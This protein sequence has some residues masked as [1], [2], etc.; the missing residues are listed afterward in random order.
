ML[1][2]PHGGTLIN[3]VLKPEKAEEAAA[4][5]AAG[6][7]ITIDRD[8]RV[9]VE[10]IA[11]GVYSPLEGFLGQK[12]LDYVLYHRRLADGIPWTIP[13]ALDVTHEQADSFQEGSPVALVAE[14]GEVA[15]VLHLEEKYVYNRGELARAVFDTD[16]TAHPGVA[17]VMQMKDV[18]LGG[19]IDLVTPMAN[20]FDRY[21]LTPYETR[22]LFRERGW[23]TVVAF[24]T[25]NVPHAGH[26]NLQKTVLGLCD[27]LL[28]HPVIGRK[29]SGDF[30]DAAIL[31]A[32]EALIANYY[33]QDR[34]VLSILRTRMRYAGPREA[35]HHAILRKNFGCTHIIIGRD[36]AGVGDFYHPEAAIEI[37]AE[38]EDLD[39]HPITIRGDFFYCEHCGQIASD[40]TCPHPEDNHV[41]FSGTLIR[42]GIRSG[43]AP[44]PQI[45]RPEVFATLVE[46]EDPFVP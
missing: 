18:L 39:I 36:H 9:D 19:K 37:F 8:T 42:K 10:N 33:P 27:G 3:R 5:V 44:P 16:D 28:I 20:P 15:A 43:Q 6:P 34:V 46:G 30:T 32:Y 12:N 40:R 38:F 1:I 29:K 25:R 24:Q 21:T 4:Q 2:E 35:I 7:R 22:V 11:T 13:I 31:R 26:E 17:R 41:P 23:Q 14:D 45:M